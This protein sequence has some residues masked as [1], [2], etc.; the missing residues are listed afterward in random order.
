MCK[1]RESPTEAQWESILH[2]LILWKRKPVVML[3]CVVKATASGLFSGIS[4]SHNEINWTSRSRL[5]EV[6]QTKFC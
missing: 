6:Y 3:E 1:G 5:V 4:C 2:L